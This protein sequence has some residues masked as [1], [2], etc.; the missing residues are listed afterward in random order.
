MPEMVICPMCSGENAKC[1]LCLGAGMITEFD[2]I[3]PRATIEARRAKHSAGQRSS[4]EEILASAFAMT[5]AKAWSSAPD[6]CRSALVA[7]AEEWP[8]CIPLGSKSFLIKTAKKLVGEVGEND[9]PQFIHWAS[10]I[11]KYDKQELID[12]IKSLDSFSF[13]IGKWR[14]E[15]EDRCPECGRDMS[16]CRHEWGS[17]KRT[18]RYGGLG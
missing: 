1:E 17:R 10:Q 8:E 18:E 13:L 16:T 2:A 7:F 15:R 3:S 9:A 11:V 5:Q 4:K 6:D 14:R 12:S